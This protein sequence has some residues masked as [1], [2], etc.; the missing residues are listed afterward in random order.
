LADIDKALT[1]EPDNSMIIFNR[2][3]LKKDM[4]YNAAAK[5]ELE[6]LAYSLNN[7]KKK[8]ELNDDEI[9]ILDQINNLSNNK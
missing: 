9:K 1:L 8:G 3:L 5:K 2:A 7:K 4:G 6:K